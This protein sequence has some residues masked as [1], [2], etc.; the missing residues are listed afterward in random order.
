MSRLAATLTALAALFAASALS[1]D[2]GIHLATSASSF[3]SAVSGLFYRQIEVKSETLLAYDKAG[4]E[5]T[6]SACL[7]APRWGY[8]L[9]D[10]SLIQKSNDASHAY[11]KLA[12]QAPK[13]VCASVLAKTGERNHTAQVEAHIAARFMQL[14]F[15]PDLPTTV[16]V[17]GL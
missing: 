8:F 14:I 2:Q 3:W 15:F 12:D 13:R 16:R 9:E 1:F 17:R 11:G 4:D 7:I 5:N 6:Q 10:A